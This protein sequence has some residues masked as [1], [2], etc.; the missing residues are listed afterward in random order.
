MLVYCGFV[1]PL[2]QCH[3]AHLSC[4]VVVVV[5]HSKQDIQF[6][7]WTDVSAKEPLNCMGR[8]V[9]ASNVPGWSPRS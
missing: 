1:G 3:L 9:A 4:I 8:Q 6:G 2:D 7:N 5:I